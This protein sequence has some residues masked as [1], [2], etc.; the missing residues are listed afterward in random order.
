MTFFG[1]Y[2][3]RLRERAGISQ[4]TLAAEAEISSAYISQIESGR[5]NPPTPDVL[6]RMAAP[7]GVPYIVLMRQADHVRDTDLY[8]LLAQA[9]R[10]LFVQDPGREQ[11][12]IL[13]REAV[14]RWT[15]LDEKAREN[16]LSAVSADHIGEILLEALLQKQSDLL[17]E[18]LFRADDEL[19][20][21]EPESV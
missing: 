17:F 2:L 3:R 11:L 16:A 15:Q 14:D 5:R 9:I 6:R 12:E 21:N 1:E 13:L 4:E 18:Q 7:L 19:N 10:T 20:D 8:A